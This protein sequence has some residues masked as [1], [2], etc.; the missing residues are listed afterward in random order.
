LLTG[1]LGALDD[2]FVLAVVPGLVALAFFS[3]PI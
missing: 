3:K 2:G 1:P